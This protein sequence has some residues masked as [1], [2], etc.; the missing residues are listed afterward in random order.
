MSAECLLT[1]RSLPFRGAVTDVDGARVA[2]ANLTFA[3]RN[4][5]KLIAIVRDESAALLPDSAGLTVSYFIQT[6]F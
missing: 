1:L 2:R 3:K 5:S 4:V 6:R